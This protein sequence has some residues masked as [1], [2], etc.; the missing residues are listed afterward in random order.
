[1]RKSVLM[2]AF[3]LALLNTSLAQRALEP[4]ITDA[5]N[6]PQLQEIFMGK[7]AYVILANE[8]VNAENCDLSLFKLDRPVRFWRD[9]IRPE[10]GMYFIEARDCVMFMDVIYDPRN[11]YRVLVKDLNTNMNVFLAKSAF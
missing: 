5:L 2:L 1:M 3:L 10:K 11:G 9:G 6:S 4:V 7:S 8:V